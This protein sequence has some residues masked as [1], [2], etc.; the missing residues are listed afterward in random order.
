MLFIGIDNP[1]GA[2]AFEPISFTTPK[3]TVYYKTMRLEKKPTVRLP[4]APKPLSHTIKNFL[5]T[6]NK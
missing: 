3:T 5:L 1:F 2:H 4:R 6:Y